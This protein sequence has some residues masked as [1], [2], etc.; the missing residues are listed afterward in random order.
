[1]IISGFLAGSFDPYHFGSLN[2]SIHWDIFLTQAFTIEMSLV[3][4]ANN[5]VW[6]IDAFCHTLQ[7]PTLLITQGKLVSSSDFK[8]RDPTFEKFNSLFLFPHFSV[9][10]LQG[11]KESKAPL[12]QFLRI[13]RLKL[14]NNWFVRKVQALTIF[15]FTLKKCF[16]LRVLVDPLIDAQDTVLQC[17]RVEQLQPEQRW[18]RW[19]LL[20]RGLAA[21]QGT[22]TASGN[23]HCRPSLLC[24][25]LLL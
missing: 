19:V 1:M 21:L 13:M 23:L 18:M 3:W 22:A 24:F 14:K 25:Q 20:Q 15:Y 12:T 2:S 7:F 10:S 11:L 9:S 6:E 16:L 17:L 5:P 8:H 4:K